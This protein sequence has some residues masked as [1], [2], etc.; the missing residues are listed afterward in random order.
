MDIDSLD[1]ELVDRAFKLQEKI[2]REGL[3]GIGYMEAAHFYMERN[4]ADTVSKHIEKE[5][6][7]QFGGGK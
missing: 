6:R 4:A 3:Q 1:P 2:K 7:S 5:L